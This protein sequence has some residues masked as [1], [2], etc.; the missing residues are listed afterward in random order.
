MQITDMR[1]DIV[2]RELPATGLESDLGRFAGTTE[3]GVLHIFTDQ[4]IEGNCSVGEF[5]GGGHG[6]FYPVLKVLKP[7]NDSIN[8]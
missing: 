8:S 5:R 7:N 1:I 3:Q 6:L 4:G 2:R